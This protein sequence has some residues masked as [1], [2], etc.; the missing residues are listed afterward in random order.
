[1]LLWMP[2][3]NIVLERIQF[4][5]HAR[6]SATPVRVLIAWDLDMGIAYRVSK[7]TKS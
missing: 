6:L 5:A 7:L 4:N 1:M 3:K 2:D